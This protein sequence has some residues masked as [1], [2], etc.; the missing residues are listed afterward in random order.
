MSQPRLSPSQN[1]PRPGRLTY[2]VS[3][4]MAALDGKTGRSRISMLGHSPGKAAQLA[5]VSR[6]AIHEAI[7]RGSLDAYY[8]H[9]DETGKLRWVVVSDASLHRYIA[10]RGRR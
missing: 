2:S 4:Y 9:D 1:P 5:G 6:Q 8:V 7:D 10:R 3:E